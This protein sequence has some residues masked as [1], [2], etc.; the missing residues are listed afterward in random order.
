[1]TGFEEE[2]GRNSLS[3]LLSVS[4]RYGQY[5]SL[6]CLS[7]IYAQAGGLWPELSQCNL[8]GQCISTE[9]L[10]TREGQRDSGVEASQGTLLKMNTQA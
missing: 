8:V 3:L 1:M 10:G 5:T 4:L 2:H 9:T 6:S 7:D